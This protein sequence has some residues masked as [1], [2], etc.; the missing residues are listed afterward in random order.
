MNRDRVRYMFIHRDSV[1]CASS[2]FNAVDPVAMGGI[3]V[4]NTDVTTAVCSHMRVCVNF[5]TYTHV[6]IY[7]IQIT[8]TNCSICTP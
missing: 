4:S 2:Y 1:A 8:Y 7:A 3:S 6:G 5:C